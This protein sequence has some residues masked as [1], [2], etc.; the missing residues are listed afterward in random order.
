M[1]DV[2]ANELAVVGLVAQAEGEFQLA[3]YVVANTGVPLSAVEENDVAI[4][5]AMSF[6]DRVLLGYGDDSVA[7]LGGAH[8]ACEGISN[9]ASI[10]LEDSRLGISPLEKSTRYV[11]FNRKINGRYRII[12][13]R[14]L[15]HQV[16]VCFMKQ[17]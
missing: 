14:Q 6:Y 11:P 5:R 17:H 4:Q 16:I 10:A 15:W 13:N 9:I 2:I 3:G 12:G 1:P 7:E 8:I